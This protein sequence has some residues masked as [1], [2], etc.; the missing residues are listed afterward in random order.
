M[1]QNS[2][3][4][5]SGSI[6]GLLGDAVVRHGPDSAVPSM[7]APMSVHQFRRIRVAVVFGG[8]SS[9]HAISCVTAGSVLRAIDPQRYEVVP[10][11]ITPKGRW[12][13]VPADPDR[14]AI[15]DGRLPEVPDDGG[16]VVLP[17]SA[18][19]AEI[20]VSEAGAP[21]TTLGE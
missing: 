19:A 9:E 6:R 1:H 4:G 15:T 2:G 13:L 18:G 11:G 10:I 21:P 20:V 12:V 14:L 7:V 5:E 16:T 17:S 3:R 8:R